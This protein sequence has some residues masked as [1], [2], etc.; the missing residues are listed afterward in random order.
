MKEYVGLPYPTKAGVYAVRQGPVIA[1]N[2]MNMIKKQQLQEYVPQKEF[3]SLMMTGDERCIGAKY[4]IAFSG[5]WV[6]H[7]KDYIDRAFM[8]L[9]DPNYLFENYKE[10]GCAKPLDNNELFDDDDKE[11]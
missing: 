10:N 2:L 1:Q 6:W 9:F 8:K 7:M 5:R 11:L 4:G 3:L